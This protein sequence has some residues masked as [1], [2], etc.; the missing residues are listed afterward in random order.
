MKT[1]ILDLIPRIQ[2]YSKKL[3]LT[4]LLKDNH[5]V[6]I[7][8]NTDVK[9]VFIFRSNAK[10]LIAE[11]GLVQK[12]SWELLTKKSLLV[13]I[14]QNTFVFKQ[15]FNIFPSHIVVCFV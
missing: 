13:S 8:E 6:C 7:S 5:S 11:N 3:D 9:T 10:L 12:G 15:A 2:K 4:S 1:F 14:N